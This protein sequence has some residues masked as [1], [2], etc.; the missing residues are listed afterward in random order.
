MSKTDHKIRF[1]Y[2]TLVNYNPFLF[3]IIIREL[4][5]KAKEKILDLGCARGF[6]VRELEKYTDGITG[7]DISQDAVRQGVTQKIK[8]GDVTKLD[9][10]E[11]TFD[12]IYSLHTIEHVQDLEKFFREAERVLKSGGIFLLVYPFELFRGMQA[13]GTATINYKNPLSS[14]K[15]HLHKLNPKK[16]QGLI[17]KT[18]FSHVKSKLVIAL[19]FQYLTVLKKN[20]PGT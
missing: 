15:I 16:I 12:K 18:S 10:K 20:D 5:P 1:S 11:N 7:I 9:F 14:R 8:C 17:K 6:Y 4:Q 13:L 3:K 19:G 2:K